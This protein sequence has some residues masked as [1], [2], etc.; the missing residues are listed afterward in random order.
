MRKHLYILLVLA[1]VAGYSCQESTDIEMEKEAIV[2]VI[3]EER[4]AYFDKDIDRIFALWYQESSSRK[5]DVC[6]YCVQTALSFS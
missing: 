3:E 2:A 5:I 4:D 6:E 1:L